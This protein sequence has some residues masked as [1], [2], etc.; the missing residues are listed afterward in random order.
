MSRG[1]DDQG[2]KKERSPG[3]AIALLSCLAVFGAGAVFLVVYAV[4]NLQ[5]N[6][7]FL[8]EVILPLI[9]IVG[10]IALLATL[11]IAAATFGLFGIADAKQALGLPAGS[12]Q[13]VIALSL[14]LIF[15]VVALYAT[16]SSGQKNEVESAG[17]TK[18]EFDAIP[19]EDLVSVERKVKGK[20]RTTKVTYDVLSAVE[21]T[22]SQE[23]NIQLLT[24]VSTLV[25]AVAGF[26]FGAKSVQEGGK[27]AQEGIIEAVGGG[28]RTLNVV[29]PASPHSMKRD[30]PPLTV[31]LESTPPGAKLRWSVQGDEKGTLESPEG[32]T[33]SFTPGKE[34]EKPGTATLSFEQVDDPKVSTSLVVH[35]LP[36]KPP[37]EKQKIDGGRGKKPPSGPK[38]GPPKKDGK[39]PGG[40]KPRKGAPKA[41]AS[42]AAKARQQLGAAAVAA[43]TAAYLAYKE[44]KDPNEAQDPDA[45][46]SPETTEAS[47]A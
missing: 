6:G 17:L 32:D 42:K 13:A 35:L 23:L 11:A 36:A 47:E 16:S 10:V 1:G 44:A 20:G 41:P 7:G 39:R 28:T 18:A 22:S 26:Y 43:V 34:G 24:T 5:E 2:A 29:E 14:I 45:T 30:D 31:K 27:S 46:G 9:V 19:R 25:V 8:P 12:V 40:G 4:E 3:G 15:A 38:Q 37:E 33:F 21:D